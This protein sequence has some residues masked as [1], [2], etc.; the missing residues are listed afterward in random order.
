MSNIKIVL[1]P[2]LADALM[3]V[4]SGIEK[5]HVLDKLYGALG[6]QFNRGY[7]Y[8]LVESSQTHNVYGTPM[9]KLVDKRDA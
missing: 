6:S 7:R 8:K 4:M 2:D 3:T 9:L 5:G 1:T